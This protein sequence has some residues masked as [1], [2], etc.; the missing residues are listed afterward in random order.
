MTNET[1][2]E[3]NDDEEPDE[4]QHEEEEGSVVAQRLQICDD[5]RLMSLVV[6]DRVQI[7][8][9]QLLPEL[10]LVGA[11]IADRASA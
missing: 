10:R 3:E 6:V 11:Q 1:H 2:L 7:L 5:L 8:V 9:D 4:V